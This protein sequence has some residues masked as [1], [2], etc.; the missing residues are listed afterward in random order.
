MSNL[1]V[2]LFL[3]VVVAGLVAANISVYFSGGKVK[4]VER[5]TLVEV[6]GGVTRLSIARKGAPVTE[7]VRPLREWRLVKPYAGSVDEHV[8]LKLI[9]A[10][11]L[12]RVDDR[13]TDSELLRM[14]RSRADFSLEEPILTVRIE[15]ESGEVESIA[16]GAPTPSSDGV[17][18]SVDGESS[19]F[20]VPAGLLS[21]ADISAEGFRRRSLFLSESTAVTSFNIKRGSGSLLEFSRSGD[22]WKMREGLAAKQKIDRFLAELTATKATSFVW[23]VGASNETEHA[24]TSLLAGYGLDPDSAVTVTLKG[25]DG[26]DRQVSLGKEAGGGR[27]FALV[28]NGGAIVTVPSAL[29]DV[30]VQDA[31][32]FTD[33]RLFPV[34]A[35]SVATFSLADGDVMYTLARNKDGQWGM[36]TPIIAPVDQKAVE[37]VLSRV[38]ALSPADVAESD[39]IAVAIATNTAALKVSRER[40]LGSIAFEDL[41][42]KEMLRVDPALV[43]RIVRTPSG[44]N[45]KPVAVVFDRERRT[46]NLESGEDGMAADAKG[47]ENVLAAINPLLAI[48]VAKMKLPASELETFGLDAPFLTVA[49][50]TSASDSVRRNIIIGKR[51]KGGRFATIGASDAVFVI[52]DQAVEQLSAEIVAPVGG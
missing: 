46:W 22:G 1:K 36:E 31:V 39:S 8:V 35:R 52:S 4:V 25:V 24:T 30:A 43:K 19:V 9:D 40:V 23:P 38:L 17:Y 41:R 20:V 13:I 16:F 14:G 3:L 44:S 51:T 21:A 27:V 49:I 42:S 2:I 48:R 28:Q 15:L 6:Q 5:Q 10:L 47:V 33:S 32:M 12:T 7:L 50:D 34:E 29:R 26:T 18:A 37:I 45:A 11:A